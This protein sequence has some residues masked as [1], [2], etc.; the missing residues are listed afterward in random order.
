MTHR[1][2]RAPSQRPLRVGE[3]L[4]HSLAMVFER[5]ELRDP[6]L[7]E[8][9]LTVTEVRVSPDLR[10]AAIYVVPLGG[11]HGDDVLAALGRAK[12]FLKSRIAE[13]VRLRY[14]PDFSFRLDETFEHASRIN[15]LIVR[16]RSADAGRH[17]AD[18]ERT[19]DDGSA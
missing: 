8:V 3:E 5:G 1:M 12:G 2:E 18:D 6:V 13:R 19:G 10:Q 17:A 9:S 7:S 14:M 15:D 11:A 16:T 4:R